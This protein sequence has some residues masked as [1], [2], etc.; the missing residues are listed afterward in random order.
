MITPTRDEV[1]DALS[2]LGFPAPIIAE[3][4]TDLG[5]TGTKENPDLCPVAVYLLRQ[6]RHANLLYFRVS[7]E[8]VQWE[9]VDRGDHEADRITE[10]IRTPDDICEFIYDFDEGLYPDLVVE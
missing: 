1:Y 10:Y 4:L 5:C 7:G 2:N 6:F 3:K 9:M 8:T